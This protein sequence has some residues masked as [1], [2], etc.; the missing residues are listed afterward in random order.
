MRPDGIIG[1]TVGLALS[2]IDEIDLV[3]LSIAIPVVVGIIHIAI[4]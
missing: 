4:G 1:T 3:Y 2:S